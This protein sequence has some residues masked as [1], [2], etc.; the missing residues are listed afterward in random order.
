MPISLLAMRGILAACGLPG[1]VPR[2]VF[3]VFSGYPRAYALAAFFRR[4]AAVVST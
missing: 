4:F 3:L 1:A 2:T